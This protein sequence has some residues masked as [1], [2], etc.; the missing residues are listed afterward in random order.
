[1]SSVPSGASSSWW[2]NSSS[3][4]AT[5]EFD[6]LL[7]TCTSENL[8]SSTPPPITHS[9]NL[10][11]LIR[12]SAVP[13][14]HA[15]KSLLKRLNHPNPNV[16][17]L[18]IS[19]IDICIKNGGDNFL[20]EISAKQFSED[21]AQIISN[22]NS[23]REV[24]LKL[25]TD[26]QN[27]ALAFESVPILS[28]SELVSNYKKLKNIQAI[29]FPPKDPLAT[30]AMVDSMSA[31]EWR[32]SQVCERCRTSFSFT[33]RKHHCRNCG[34]VFDGQCSSKR[35][36][37][38]H[39]GVSELVRVCDGCERTLSTSSTGIY[40][41]PNNNT[42]RRNS[43]SGLDS[44]NHPTSSSKLSI[45]GSHHQRSATI[46]SGNSTRRYTN[47]GEDQERVLSREEADLERAIA[48]SLQE[49]TISELQRASFPTSSHKPHPTQDDDPN[50]EPELAAAIAASLRESNPITQTYHPSAPMPISPTRSLETLHSYRPSVPHKSKSEEDL[51]SLLSF[52]YDLDYAKRHG[53]LIPSNLDLINS[54]RQAEFAKLNLIKGIET[55]EHK[56]SIL[57]EMNQKLS[58]AVKLYDR[59]LSDQ[60]MYRTTGSST[61]YH[62]QQVNHHPQQAYNQ[63][64][65]SMYN[66]PPP[67][68]PLL[69][70]QD[71]NPNL[72]SLTPA[73]DSQYHT[74]NYTTQ[75]QP[76]YGY[77]QQI[78]VSSAPLTPHDRIDS[79]TQ[80][81]GFY[82]PPPAPAP[83][84]QDDNHHYP[85]F[86]QPLPSQYHHQH[87]HAMISHHS[88][89][90][91]GGEVSK[92][93]DTSRH[94]PINAPST[95]D[96]NNLTPQP[97]QQNLPPPPPQ[98]QQ[99]PTFSH[100]PSQIPVHG[101][102]HTQHQFP[103]APQ[104][105]LPSTSETHLPEFP[106]VPNTQLAWSNHTHVHP[107]QFGGQE[108]RDL[109]RQDDVPPLIE[110]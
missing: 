61:S 46:H 52:T 33:N 43:F 40:S 58:D 69:G 6:K 51:N 81:A 102:E 100:L 39:F 108:S 36:V 64:G 18:S 101:Q 84:S 68:P 72:T 90:H 8:P 83:H 13:A 10:S 62:P 107:H 45:T 9:L 50:H 23:N 2:W 77:P 73:N 54:Y 32:D 87:S 97:A 1:M 105:A 47:Q 11:D 20:K 93:G 27:W 92:T 60:I 56:T 12:S 29:D 37:L 96:P 49:S 78:S 17:L 94:Q 65:T 82:P 85:Q 104:S 22:P 79:T 55:T 28:N 106:N 57:K 70:R 109:N 19:V 26:F 95:I 86:A 91:E 3:A 75:Q 7:E 41:K 63:V 42:I 44:T 110:F 59:L 67:P 98:Q 80:S 25:K 24:R 99:Q 35:R 89:D 14:S 71:T 31:P 4:N 16:Q 103:S 34:G 88:I 74:P 30:A 66:H 53:Q 5:T 21:C 38:P 48:L 76:Q 15:L